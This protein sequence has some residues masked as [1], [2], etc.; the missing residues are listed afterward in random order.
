MHSKAG[1]PRNIYIGGKVPT[2]RV[3]N[4]ASIIFLSAR[5]FSSLV[6]EFAQ[7]TL[8][9]LCSRLARKARICS[10]ILAISFS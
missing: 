6:A 2:K 5:C 8:S 4:L 9:V 3:E 1:L 10:R 7:P